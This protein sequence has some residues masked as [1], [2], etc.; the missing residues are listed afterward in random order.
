MSRELINTLSS[1]STYEE[2]EQFKVVYNILVGSK[3][4]PVKSNKKYDRC[5]K[6]GYDKAVIMQVQ[7]RSLDEEATTILQCDKCGG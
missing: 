1:N 2:L 7:T 6:C 3:L 5:P 4:A